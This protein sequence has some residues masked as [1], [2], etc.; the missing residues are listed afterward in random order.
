MG[1]DRRR[2][3]RAV[4]VA[5]PDGT[6]RHGPHACAPSDPCVRARRRVASHRNDGVPAVSE[7]RELRR[8]GR[9]V[10]GA[11]RGVRTFVAKGT[12]PERRMNVRVWGT[13]GS[14]ASPGPR[15][16]RYGGNTSCIGVTRRDGTPLAL[17][18]GSGIR[19]LGVALEP[20]PD[21]PVHVLL[22]HLHMDHLQGLAFFA[23]LWS[24]GAEVHVW[25]PPSTTQ[26]LE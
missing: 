20:D 22:S 21:R 6:G 16:V 9:S 7:R 1:D 3:R 13:C 26:S 11:R 17:D 4:V 8:R 5:G 25:G 12:V 24:A 15:T 23:P 10:L 2:R 14:L 19:E 18:A